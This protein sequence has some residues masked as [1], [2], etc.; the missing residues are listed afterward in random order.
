MRTIM[1]GIKTTLVRN[2]LRLDI[3]KEKNSKL[4]EV[5]IEIIKNKKQK[6]KRIYKNEQR[7][8]SSGPTS[9]CLIFM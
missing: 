1:T 6:E 9:S 2:N 7:S 8:V 5:T 3:S 4:K